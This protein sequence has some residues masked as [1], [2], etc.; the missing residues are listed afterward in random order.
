MELPENQGVTTRSKS[1]RK[2]MEVHEVVDLVLFGDYV[3]PPFHW[4]GETP[5]TPIAVSGIVRVFT[6]DIY[7]GSKY[8][9]AP[10]SNSHAEELCDGIWLPQLVADEL[11][12]RIVQEG[13]GSIVEGKFIEEAYTMNRESILV[14]DKTLLKKRYMAFYSMLMVKR[15]AG[16]VLLHKFFVERVLPFSTKKIASKFIKDGTSLEEASTMTWVPYPCAFSTHIIIS[17]GFT[18]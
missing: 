16:K 12:E 14:V 15:K 1:K 11:H 17:L 10:G 7:S 5:L 2:C 4:K 6:A 3:S 9:G 18:S 13:R 8:W